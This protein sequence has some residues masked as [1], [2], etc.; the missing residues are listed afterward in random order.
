MLCV[1]KVSLSDWGEGQRRDVDP[2]HE[3]IAG[4]LRG[5]YI[6]PL[7]LPRRLV[8]PAE[9][10]GFGPDTPLSPGAA[11]PQD[12]AQATPT[13]RKARR[14]TVKDSADE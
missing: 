6:V 10:E 14:R 5:G 11:S 3:R 8:A 4:L 2:T 7:E 9:P 12:A 13:P 1:A